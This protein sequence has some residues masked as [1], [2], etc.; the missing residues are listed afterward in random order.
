M[1]R[2]LTPRCRRGDAMP[3]QP[4]ATRKFH[5]RRFRV[6]RNDAGPVAGSARL[7]CAAVLGELALMML[8]LLRRQRRCI[9]SI[10]L[11]QSLA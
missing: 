6:G 10:E 7:E 8:E 2:S 9:D 3:R 11:L 5:Q 1:M 4:R